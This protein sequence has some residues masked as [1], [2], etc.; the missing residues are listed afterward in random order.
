MKRI[1]KFGVYQTSKVVAILLFLSSLIFLIPFGL[2]MNMTV[3]NHFPGFPFG[4]GVFFIVLPIL[5]GVMGFIMTAIGCLIY[6]AVVKWTGGIEVEFE[7][8]VESN[9]PA[10]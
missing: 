1:S 9:E 7:A 3:G 4:E 5:Y 6:N 8:V 10:E 2:F